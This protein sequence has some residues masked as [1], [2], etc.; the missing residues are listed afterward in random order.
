[1]LLYNK[2]ADEVNTSNVTINFADGTTEFTSSENMLVGTTAPVYIDE[3]AKIYGLSG[4][5]FVKNNALGNIGANKAYI[6]ASSIPAEVKNFT[7]VF[8][9][10]TTGITETRQATREE[11]EAIFNLSGQKLN[12]MQRGINIVNGKKVIIK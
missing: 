8:E 6:L 10:E 7:F 4:S 1:M 11:V 2:D 3:V 12:K 9:D 5:S